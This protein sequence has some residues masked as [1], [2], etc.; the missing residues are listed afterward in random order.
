MFWR[1][2]ALLALLGM[3]AVIRPAPALA[4]VEPYQAEFL[5]SDEEFN[6]PYAMSCDQIQTFLNERPGILKG[7]VDGDKSAAQHICEQANRFGI[8]PRLLLTMVQ[9]EQG[10]LTARTPS[11]YAINW[12][13]GCGPGWASTKGFGVQMECAARTLRRRFDN[14]ALGEMVDGVTPINRA[15]L[16]LYRYTTHVAGNLN[17]WRIWNGYWPASAATPMPTEIVVDSRFAETTPKLVNDCRKGWVVGARAG[18][19]HH[20]VT[21]NVASAAESTN[22]VVWRPNLPRAGVYQVYVFVPN[23]A[24][25]MWTCGGGNPVWDTSSARY[26]VKHRDGDTTYAVNQAPLHDVWVNIGAYYFNAGM[27]GYVRLS[28]VTGEPSL[29]RYVSFDDVKFVFMGQ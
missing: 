8:N 10:L 7:F 1:W 6:D 2:I 28:D 5:I 18:D 22:S 9:K 23:R 15:T 11:D 12:A 24:A 19:G 29:T 25:L 3:S 13:A 16:A 27:D 20:F 26:T 4:L 17:F 14:A 21:P